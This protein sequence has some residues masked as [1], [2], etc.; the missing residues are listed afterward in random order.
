LRDF[1]SSTI[2]AEG[3]MSLIYIFAASA[4]EGAPVH[5][6]AV[7]SSSSLPSRCGPNDLVLVTGGMGPKNARSKAE[8]AFAT[9]KPDAVLVIGLCGGL[10]PSLPEGRVVAYT[11]CQSTEATNSPLHC[12]YII[13]DLIV[14]L[15]K[16]S[17]ITCD[18]V[19][20]IT[21]SRIATTRD[22]RS[23]LARDG[24]TV[25]DMESYSIVKAATN[26]GT[27]VVVLRVVGDSIDQELPDFNRALNDSGALDGRKAF[28][29][30][31]GSPLR[32][33]RLLAA[34]RRA[35]QRISGALEIV[36]KAG[37]FLQSKSSA[38][39]PL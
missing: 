31:L 9:G 27:P 29:V 6:I 4:M 23:A 33:A 12:S 25:V 1:R 7:P 22:E 5:K 11:E 18:R 15:L 37:C 28:K 10:T 3:Q 20:G 13:T 32:T 38:P 21:S 19:V 30:A 26:A 14:E 16:S 8:A 24:A 2:E 39:R 35:M 34:S 36:L 17:S